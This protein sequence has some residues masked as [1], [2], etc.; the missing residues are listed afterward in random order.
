MLAPFPRTPDV[1]RRHIADYYACVTYLD[2]QVGR[3][4]QTLN[5]RGLADNTIVVFSSDQGLAVGGLHG[6]MGKQNLYECNKPPLVFFG[7]GIP[8]GESDALV[9]LYDLFPTF[10]EL[11]GIEIPDT[12]EGQSLLPIIRGE[13]EKVRQWAFGAYKACQRMIRDDRWKLI[14][15]HAAGQKNRQLFDLENDPEEIHNLAEDPAVADHLQRLEAA[16]EKARQQFGDPVD[17]EGEGGP[18][19]QKRKPKKATSGKRAKS[20]R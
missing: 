11:A 7:P 19:S 10:C 4:F 14:K 13:E 18:A 15:Y 5:E 1:M 8:R 17:F 20:K 9:Y 12:V 2:V 6:L 16:L 3:I